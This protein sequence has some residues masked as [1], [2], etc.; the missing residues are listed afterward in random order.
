MRVAIQ[1]RRC[2]KLL[3]VKRS[4]PH[5]N[6][7]RTQRETQWYQL[8]SLKLIKADRGR[9]MVE[10]LVGLAHYCMRWVLCQLSA[11]KWVSHSFISATKQLSGCPIVLLDD[12]WSWVPTFSQQVK[13]HVQAGSPMSNL[14][15]RSQ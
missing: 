3:P 7:R 2:S 4:S 8:V 6:A 15:T 10:L 12:L 13:T 5:K 1:P 9:V 11:T 14:L